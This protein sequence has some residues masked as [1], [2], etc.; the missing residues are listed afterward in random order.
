MG[1]L[2]QEKNLL[3]ESVRE[4]RDVHSKTMGLYEE[5]KYEL[6][7]SINSLTEE[8]EDVKDQLEYYKRKLDVEEHERSQVLLEKEKLVIEF[9]NIDQELSVI[10]NDHKSLANVFDSEK[11]QLEDQVTLV[12][13]D[14][15]K[16]RLELMKRNEEYNVTLRKFEQEIL[17]KRLRFE[18]DTLAMSQ[19]VDYNKKFRVDL[20]IEFNNLTK[21]FRELHEEFSE[22]KEKLKKSMLLNEDLDLLKNQVDDLKQSSTQ[23]VKNGNLEKIELKQNIK[24]L[25]EELREAKDL[26]DETHESYREKTYNLD[27]H[28]C[29]LEE[30]LD[31][32]IDNLAKNQMVLKDENID[33][34]RLLKEKEIL[35]KTILDYEKVIKSQRIELDE[36]LKTRHRDRQ[37]N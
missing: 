5:E 24:F 11:R 22:N 14:S 27:K 20:E 32:E 2:A 7:S 10:K 30:K 18:K 25:E 21:D 1:I 33:K 17:E 9:K 15:E 31:K 8:L 29:F 23:E 3:E 16:H 36:Y 35:K 4:I 37:S 26:L 13:R 28:C 34:E 12:K 19:D 6:N